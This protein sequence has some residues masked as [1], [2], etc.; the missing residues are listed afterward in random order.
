LGVDKRWPANGEIDIMEYYR[1]KILANV[2][3]LGKDG[4]AE[5]FSNRFSTDS[6]GGKSWADKFHVWRMDCTEEFIALYCDDV[7]LNK[8][9]LNLLANK[10]GSGFNPFKQP[11]YIL[12][13]LAMGGMNGGDHTGTI[14]P[15]KFEVDYVRVY[16]EN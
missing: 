6:L 10:D 7:L 12:L 14:F 13:N 8:T 16:Q 1:G 3:C 2:A 5:W 11:H 4:Q 9:S 15:Q